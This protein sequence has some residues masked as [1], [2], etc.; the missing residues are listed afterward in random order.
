MR[1]RLRSIL[2]ATY[3]MLEDDDGDDYYKRVRFVFMC[4]INLNVFLLASQL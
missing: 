3:V 1:Q 2:L 4:V